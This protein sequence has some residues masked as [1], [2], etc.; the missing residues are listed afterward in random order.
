MVDQLPNLTGDGGRGVEV[1]PVLAVDQDGNPVSAGGQGSVDAANSTDVE[2]TSSGTFTGEWVSN[3][4]PHIGFNVKADQDGTLFVDISPD[5]GVTITLSKQYDIRAGEARFD[6]F[7][8]G[9]RSHRV[10]YVNGGSAQG[11]FVLSTF[12]GSGLY[13]FA[14]S[15]RDAPK[16]IA[17]S[18]SGISG[19]TYAMLVDLSDTTNF[20]HNDTG[21]IDLY[22]TFLLVDKAA[23]SAGSVRLGVITRIDGTDADVSLVQ[24][25]SFTNTSDRSIERDRIF[26]HP[27]KLGQSGGELTDVATA[28]K[29]T[30]VTAINTGLTLPSPRGNVTPALGDVVIQFAYTSGSAYN[31][32]VSGQYAGN[33]SAT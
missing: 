15:D 19:T 17:Y 22:S 14:I 18:G 5:G 9:P 32:S 26:D 1:T 25:V 4:D 13:P 11:S 23:N 31:A 2:L 6:A 20:P 7:V 12:T 3:T 28:F 21:R 30:G 16:F 33:V 24:G 8:K 10:R 27:L 29:L